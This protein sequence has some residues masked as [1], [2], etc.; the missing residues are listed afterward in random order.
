M[1]HIVVDNRESALFPY[2]SKDFEY[3]KDNLVLGDIVFKENMELVL[4]VERKSIDDLVQS[5]KDGRYREQKQ[6]IRESGIAPRNC[7]YLIEGRLPRSSLNAKYKGLSISAI[8]GSIL[9]SSIRDGFHLFFT[10][11]TNE[12]ALWIEYLAKKF[13]GGESP[14]QQE[15]DKTCLQHPDGLALREKVICEVKKKGDIDT[16]T[17]FQHQLCQ[18]PGISEKIALSLSQEVSSMVDFL[19]QL[20]S[21][22]DDAL[23]WLSTCQVSEKRKIGKKTSQ[24]ILNYLGFPLDSL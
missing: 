1:K 16:K 18:I 14:F 7:V 3:G 24:K 9:N 22:Q 21:K 6:R 23:S 12:T 8:W 5:I 13:Y 10:N 19:E 20:R 2:F 4:L 11:T 15:G 17:C